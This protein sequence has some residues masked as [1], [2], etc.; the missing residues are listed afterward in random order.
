MT[1]MKQWMPVFLQN[2]QESF[3]E[4]LV[5][6]GLQGSHGRGEETEQSDIDVVVILDTLTLEDLNTYRTAVADIPAR[7]KLCGFVSGRE[8]LAHWDGAELFQFYYDTTAYFGSLDFI[9][10]RIGRA[11]IRRAIHMDACKIYHGCCHNYLHGRDVS[12]LRACYKSAF[13]ILQ[14][15]YYLKTGMYI[16]RK[17]D[18]LP[19]LTD[20]EHEI[21]N[22][23]LLEDMECQFDACSERLLNWT[24]KLIQT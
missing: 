3:G 18:L 5:C 17:V 15:M 20:V 14:A 12:V 2:M 11:E 22:T 19:K 7:D 8:E 24:S 21:L 6:V 10:P 13:F 1:D 4:R 9:L 23:L 16:S